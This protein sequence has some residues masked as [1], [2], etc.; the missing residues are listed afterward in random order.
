MNSSYISRTIKP[1]QN[2]NQTE[3]QTI[4]I[5]FICF[6]ILFINRTIQKKLIT[7]LILSKIITIISI[8]R[9]N[10]ITIVFLSKIFNLSKWSDILLKKNPNFFYPN[11]SKLS[12]KRKPNQ[13]QIEILSGCLHYYPHQ[14]KTKITR[15]KPNSS[16]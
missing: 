13:N 8:F 11:Y 5:N 15:P 1:K 9:Y 10:Q 6:K 3:N 12:R 16:S 2:Q 14:P 7:L 4:Q